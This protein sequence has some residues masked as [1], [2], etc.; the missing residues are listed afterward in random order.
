MTSPSPQPV[1]CFKHQTGSFCQFK[2]YVLIFTALFSKQPRLLMEHTETENG[3][4]IPAVLTDLKRLSGK[5]VLEDGYF[6]P[7]S[8]S[9]LFS[10]S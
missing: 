10:K 5:K 3:G 7:I 9:A 8:K 6:Q 1:L 4:W 2:V